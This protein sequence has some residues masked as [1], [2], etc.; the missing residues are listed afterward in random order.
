MALEWLLPLAKKIHQNLSPASPTS[1]GLASM[2]LFQSLGSHSFRINT[3]TLTAS[4]LWGWGLNLYCK[5][6]TNRMRLGLLFRNQSSATSDNKAFFR[7]DT[8][9]F[10]SL[11][12]HL[13]WEFM[14]TWLSSCFSFPILLITIRNN[15]PSLCQYFAYFCYHI[16]VMS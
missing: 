13:S 10:G 6:A 3:L 2:L 5:S 14:S 11:M 16:M 12:H 15:Q 7:V 1:S 8:E 4:I 9:T